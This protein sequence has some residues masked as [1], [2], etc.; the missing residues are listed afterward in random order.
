MSIIE[1]VDLTKFY[2]KFRGI[3]DVNFSVNE[4]EIFGFI[5]P[6]GSGKSTTIRTLLGLIKPQSGIGKIFDLD[7]VKNSEEIRKRVGYM[8]SEAIFYSNMQVEDIIDLSGKLNKCNCRAEALRLCSALDLPLKKR[9]SE[10]SLGNRK[11]LAIVCA[12]AHKPDLYIFDEPTS[13]LDPLIQKTFFELVEERNREGAT[14]FLS[15]HVLSEI[16]RYCGRAAVI[17]EGR[18]VRLDSIEN[19]IKTNSRNVHIHGSIELPEMVEIKNLD[20]KSNY[21]DFVYTGD[22][23]LLIKILA[24]QRMEDITISEPDLEDVVINYYQGEEK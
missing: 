17:K 19:L 7:C 14:V 12:M 1:T 10:L 9:V 23:N 11:K 22:I 18:I 3:V 6:N 21:A 4:G 24:D 8:S 20:H 2:G 13:G 15:S 5:G 16:Q